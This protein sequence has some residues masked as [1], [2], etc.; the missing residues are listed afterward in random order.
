VQS[1]RVPAG[2]S[3]PARPLSTVLVAMPFA[4]LGPSIQLGLLKAIA[5]GAGF[6]TSTRHFFLDFAHWADVGRYKALCDHGDV[7]AAE[8]LFAAEAFRDDEGG[9]HR[10]VAALIPPW[11]PRLAEAAGW[12]V[13]E[14]VDFRTN[15]V[16]AFLTHLVDAEHWDRFDVVGFTSTFQQNTASIALARRLKDRWPHL[17]ILFG[18]ANFDGPMGRAFVRAVDVID[19]AIIGEA[20]EAFPAF[21]AAVAANED[22]AAVP[23][24]IDRR[25]VDRDRPPARHY[26]RLDQSPVPSFD[27]FFERGAR[28]GLIA[29]SAKV[30]LPFEASRGCWWGEKRHCVFCGL[31]GAT[32][33]FRAKSAE[34]V[35]AELESQGARYGTFRFDAVD[36]IADPGHFDHLFPRLAEEGRDYDLFFEV[37][38][39]LGRDRMR[40]LHKAGVRQI[41]PGIESLSSNVLKLTRKGVTAAQNVNALRWA[42]YYRVHVTWN[43]L[44]GIPGETREDYA[45]QRDLV[46]TLAHLQPPAGQGRITMQRFSPL[47][48]RREEYGVAFCVPAAAY[49][50]IY[51][52]R[53]DLEQAA[54]YFDYALENGLPDLAYKPLGEVVDHWRASWAKPLRPSMIY[55]FSPELVVIDDLRDPGRPRSI[56]LRGAE[57]RLYHAC[58]EKPVSVGLLH[59]RFAGE[60]AEPNIEEILDRWLEDRLVM[61]DGGLFLSLALPASRGR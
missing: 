7:L 56:R 1:I 37:K 19:Y 10:D 12:S 45:G 29:S 24:V 14:L 17:K 28:L 18:G 39:N 57:G 13:A 21:L 3:R 38:S 54:F 27:E 61:K 59:S 43:L 42:R 31:N 52:A 30:A 46:P 41:Q 20:D 53:V 34:R 35:L 4:T 2:V 51:P 5:E 60:L 15:R 48:E 25:S 55:R 23:G 26:D 9:G 44:W 8:W 58:G 11:L 36:N 22:P 32:M 50:D 6:E 16:P 47:F 33:K 40:T 49:G